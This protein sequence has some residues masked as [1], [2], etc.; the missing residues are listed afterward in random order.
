MCVRTLIR[1]NQFFPDLKP[2]NYRTAQISFL[3]HDRETSFQVNVLRGKSRIFQLRLFRVAA[4][5]IIQLNNQP[6]KSQIFIYI[7]FIVVLMQFIWATISIFTLS[8][9]ICL[10]LRSKVAQPSLK[11]QLLLILRGKA[12]CAKF[13][14]SYVMMYVTCNAID[15]KKD[16]N[17]RSFKW[18]AVSVYCRGLKPNWHAGETHRILIKRSFKYVV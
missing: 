3:T 12:H 6:L 1:T 2:D 9:P 17:Q 18:C 11:C 4:T 10:T 13:I 5:T 16:R 14:G 15:G 7:S 8:L